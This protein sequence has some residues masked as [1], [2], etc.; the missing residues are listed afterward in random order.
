MKKFSKT[1]YFCYLLAKK[2]PLTRDELTRGAWVMDGAK[3]PYKETSNHCY[4]TPTGGGN[5]GYVSLVHRGI[6]TKVGTRGR[7]Y[8]YDLTPLGEEIAWKVAYSIHA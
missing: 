3:I 7:K 5:G 6:I 4:F 1:G 2:G 8:V